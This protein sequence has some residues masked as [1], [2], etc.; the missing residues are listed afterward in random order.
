[1]F[2]RVDWHTTWLR[3][4][5]THNRTRP[6]LAWPTPLQLPTHRV[7]PS[8]TR[9]TPKTGGQFRST[10][11]K[12]YQKSSNWRKSNI[13]GPLAA[14]ACEL[15]NPILKTPIQLIL[16][17]ASPQPCSKRRNRAP[18]SKKKRKYLFRPRTFCVSDQI[19][20]RFVLTR[21]HTFPTTHLAHKPERSLPSCASHTEQ[22]R[23][24]VQNT[25]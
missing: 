21:K 10:F 17:L 2:E 3:Q 4:V 5:I 23:E 25:P 18:S 9:T 6:G 20:N 11:S 14:A 1:L 7:I 16:P 13:F 15:N 19:E 8:S 24:H 12:T 22:E